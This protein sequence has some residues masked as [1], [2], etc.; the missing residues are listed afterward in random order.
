MWNWR[1]RAGSWFV[2]CPNAGLDKSDSTPIR[3]TRSNKLKTSPLAS[4]FNLSP[5][6]QG[7]EKN[8][9]QVKSRLLYPGWSYVFRPRFPSCPRAGGGNADTGNSPLRKFFLDWPFR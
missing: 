4:S 9:S 7:V 6:N 3:L 2:E 5:W 8:F 1:L